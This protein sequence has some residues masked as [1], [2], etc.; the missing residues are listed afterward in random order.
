[1]KLAF[2]GP[3]VTGWQILG[4]SALGFVVSFVWLW[5]VLAAH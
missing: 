5:L 1:M 3:Q 4:A 2:K